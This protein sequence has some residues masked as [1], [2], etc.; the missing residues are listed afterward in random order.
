MSPI[1]S[2]HDP[3]SQLVTRGQNFGEPQVEKQGLDSANIDLNA[4]YTL[5][6]YPRSLPAPRHDRC[7]VDKRIG[8]SFLQ[9]PPAHS[10]IR[11]GPPGVDSAVPLCRR[12]RALVFTAGIDSCADECPAKRRERAAAQSIGHGLLFACPAPN[13]AGKPRE[14]AHGPTRSL[15]RR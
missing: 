5:E 3:A 2:I 6:G 8:L 7:A 10:L 14:E 9:H 1:L 13:G 15:A 4:R 12:H 11:D